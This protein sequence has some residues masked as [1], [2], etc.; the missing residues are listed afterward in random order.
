MCWK[1][2]CLQKSCWTAAR[3]AMLML[4]HTHQ[5]PSELIPRGFAKT[6]LVAFHLWLH[7]RL[8]IYFVSLNGQEQISAMPSSV[9]RRGDCVRQPEYWRPGTWFAHILRVQW[10]FLYKQLPQKLRFNHRLR[11]KE[12]FVVGENAPKKK[13]FISLWT[14]DTIRNA[15]QKNSSRVRVRVENSFPEHR[16]ALLCNIIKCYNDSGRRDE[17]RR[18]GDT[19][20]HKTDPRGN[21]FTFNMLTWLSVAICSLLICLPDCQ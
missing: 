10:Y 15:A 6:D 18:E 16:G 4:R 2:K 5:L 19:S 12:M 20:C 21:L 1:W 9:E 3:H 11:M 17:W 14:W 13:C 8:G 7:W